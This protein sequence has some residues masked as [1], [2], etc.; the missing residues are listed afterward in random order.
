MMSGREPLGTAWP[1]FI[2]VIG[3][4]FGQAAGWHSEGESLG[5]LIAVAAIV[6]AVPVHRALSPRLRHGFHP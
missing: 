6:V 2:G 3:V 4:L 5:F 1:G